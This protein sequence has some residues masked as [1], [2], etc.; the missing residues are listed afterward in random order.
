MKFEML[1]VD[2]EV[3]GFKIVD[4]E[5]FTFVKDRWTDFSKWQ[6]FLSTKLIQLGFDNH[7][8][9]IKL[10]GKGGFGKVYL[11]KEISSSDLVAIKKIPKCKTEESLKLI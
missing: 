2:F 5:E 7:F 9:K 1:L 8:T 6:N 10:L 11:G 3:Y 4:T